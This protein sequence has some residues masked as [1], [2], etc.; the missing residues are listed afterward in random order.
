M[1]IAPNFLQADQRYSLN[2]VG[3]V[4]NVNLSCI[5]QSL[6]MIT[7]LTC[8]MLQSLASLSALSMMFDRFPTRYRV[9]LLF[10]VF[11]TVPDLVLPTK[12]V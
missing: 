3:Q 11:V 6:T 4:T 2:P 12:R 10:A 1:N 9:P 8:L 7:S 5:G